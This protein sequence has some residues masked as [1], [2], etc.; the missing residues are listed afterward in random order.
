MT[1]TS[2]VS[3]AAAT[4]VADLPSSMSA[5][6]FL[7]IAWFICIDLNIR[8][9][10]RAARRSLYFWSCL[11]CSWGIIVHSIAILLANFNKWT[12][13]SSIVI[14]ELAWFAYVVAQSLVLYSRLNLVLKNVQIGRYILYMIIIDSVIFGLTTVLLG[15]IAARRSSQ[16]TVPY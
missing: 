13:Y 2:D 11:L 9:L 12:A 15:M 1:S 10:V 14:I 8:L 6:A 16:A 7:G 4:D 5:A 3:H